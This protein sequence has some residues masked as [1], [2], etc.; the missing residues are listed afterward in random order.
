[1]LRDL[2]PQ[3]PATAKCEDDGKPMAK[4]YKCEDDGKPMAK[5][6]KF[7]NQRLKDLGH[8]GLVEPDE[9]Q[10]GGSE[11]VKVDEESTTYH[12]NGRG[13]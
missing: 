3:Y 1:M 5:P 2:F 10:R 9:R 12:G 13:P 11:K 7:S 4:P 6:Y 8:R